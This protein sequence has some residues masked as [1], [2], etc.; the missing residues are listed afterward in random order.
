MRQPIIEKPFLFVTIIVL[1][2]IVYGS[3]YPFSFSQPSHGIGAVRT[4]LESWA[5]P[6]ERGDFL[7]N[8]L[9]YAPL[10]FFG[11]LAIRGSVAAIARFCLVLML[12]A[13]MSILMELTQYYDPGRV[14]SASDVLSN[15]LGTLVGIIGALRFSGEHGKMFALHQIRPTPPL[16]LLTVWATFRLFP[17]D[18]DIS[19]HQVWNS[20]KPLLLNPSLDPNALFRHIS[21]W[22]T[23]AVLVSSA[24]GTR[25]SYFWFAALASFLLFAK[26]FLAGAT[27]STAEIA[28]SA[29]AFCWAVASR[30]FPR[31]QI[32]ATCALL[33]C[34]VIMFRLEP[35]DLQAQ[36]KEFDWIPFFSFMHGSINVDM[37]S[38]LEKYFLYGSLIWLFVEVG[39]QLRWATLGVASL[40]FA[41][42]WMEIFLPGKSAEITDTIMALLIGGIMALMRQTPSTLNNRSTAR[43]P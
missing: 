35:F 18:P 13:S 6:V 42:S 22:V 20:L 28:G 41:T 30:N 27:I 9:F 8:I 26:L 5:A 32:I 17:F 34:Y 25:R 23:V 2:I 3:L 31:L 33:S 4:L 43:A 36:L 37:L 14:T 12:G 10:G 38:F 11:S 24:V 1:L 21:M 16:M 40:L 15:V 39:V 19:L 29:I 7:A